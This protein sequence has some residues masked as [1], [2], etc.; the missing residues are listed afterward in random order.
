MEGCRDPLA[1]ESLTVYLIRCLETKSLSSPDKK[2]II[3]SNKYSELAQNYQGQSLSSNTR[4]DN[5]YMYRAQRKVRQCRCEYQ[6]AHSTV[7]TFTSIS[8]INNAKI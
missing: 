7:M 3:G 1:F 6:R 2:T 4:I 8:Y 5:G